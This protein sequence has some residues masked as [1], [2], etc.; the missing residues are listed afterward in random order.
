LT[1]TRRDEIAGLLSLLQL[2]AQAARQAGFE[3][4]TP[5]TSVAHAQRAELRAV[6]AAQPAA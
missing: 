5:R 3:A 2:A 1:L 4:A 6:P